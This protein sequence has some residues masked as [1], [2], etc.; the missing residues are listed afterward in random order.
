ML[1]VLMDVVIVAFGIVTVSVNLLVIVIV[2][3]DDADE[4][5]HRRYNRQTC[6]RPSAETPFRSTV[7]CLLSAISPLNMT[8][9]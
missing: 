1:V 5:T 4:D 8:R 9:K 2:N 6:C 7:S 3:D